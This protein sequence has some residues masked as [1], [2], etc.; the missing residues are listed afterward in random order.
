MGGAIAAGRSDRLSGCVTCRPRGPR[1][2]PESRPR[3]DLSDYPSLRQDQLSARKFVSA[4]ERRAAARGF[5]L[6]ADA[7]SRNE[8]KGRR[9]A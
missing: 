3:R 8:G 7:W 4:M 5:N 2:R 6:A 1:S 9:A